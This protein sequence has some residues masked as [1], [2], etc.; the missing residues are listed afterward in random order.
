[1]FLFFLIL[2]VLLMAIFLF[3]RHPQFGRKPTGAGLAR[4]QQSPHYKN[5][6]FHNINPTP[7]FTKGYS[8]RKVFYDYLFGKHPRKRPVTPIRAIKTDLH[9]LPRHEDLL[10]WFG[11]SSYYLQIDG[12]RF[13]VDPVFSGNA[14]PLRGSNRAFKGSDIY[15]PDDIP[16][17]DYLLITHDHY[18][19]LDYRTVRAL[20]PRIKQVVTGL[21]TGGHLQ[22]WGYDAS[23]ITEL[24]WQENI[25]LNNNIVITAT[26][27]RHFSGRLFKRNNT[28]W[29]SFIL[30][31]KKLRLY[32]GG[33]SGYD[34][35]FKQIGDEYGPF[36]LA[37]LDNGQYNAAWRA[38][39]MFPEDVLKAAADL[40]AMRILAGHSGKFT[41]S[42]HAWDE[43][44]RR[45]TELNKNTG[46]QL[47]TPK[48]GQPVYLNDTT[49]QF[50]AWW[51]DPAKV[52]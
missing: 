5:G 28:L 15:Q 43:P 13:L 11:H 31:S 34:E 41:M 8:F 23:C 38:I 3:F 9:S 36:D 22:R 27:A 46:L 39:H 32:L 45:I 44:L 20:R 14:S 4:L 35:H 33:D 17:I 21:G 47:L 25:V 48:I 18:D 51:Q 40:R 49:Q 37:L 6:Q 30:Q 42:T 2:V 12:L 50:E 10:I 16:E 7:T 24:D 26:P 52:L 1:M 29:L 19:H